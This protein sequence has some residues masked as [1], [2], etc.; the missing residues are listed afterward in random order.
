M[1]L[2]VTAWWFRFR[3]RLRLGRPE[4][5][6]RILQLSGQELQRARDWILRE[7]QII[8]FPKDVKALLKGQTIPPTSRLRALNPQLDSAQLLRVGG[9]LGNSAL[10]YSQQH[11]VIADSQDSLIRKWFY[12][13]HLSLCHCGPTLLLSYA[14]NHLHILGARRLSRTVCSQCTVKEGSYLDYP[15]DGRSATRKSDSS[16]NIPTHWHGSGW[17]FLPQTG[18]CEEANHH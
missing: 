15:N 13:I 11:P 1:T 4:P 12:H 14:G 2:A 7:N 10:T 17:S 3:D 18:L 16:T 6:N 8:N 9:R 5:D